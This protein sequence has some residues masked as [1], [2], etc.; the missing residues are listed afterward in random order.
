MGF[1]LPVAFALAILL[2][3]IVAMYLLKLRRTEQVVSSVYLWQR[4]VRDVEAN[5]PWQRL[6]R[7]LLLILQLL[8]LVALI[9]ALA[10]PFTWAQGPASEA[11]IL[12]LDTSASMAATD[13][14]PTR[15]G[16]AQAEARRLVDGLPP[17]ARVTVLAAGEGARLLVASSQDRQAIYRAI[18]G[19]TPG[20]ATSDLTAALELASAVAAR[21]PDTEIVV[22]SDGRVSLPQQLALSGRVRYVPV[23][24]SGDNQAI[25]AL[26]LEAESD[27]TLTAFAQVANYGDE[28]VQRRLALLA[29]GQLVSAYDLEIE[30]GG[31]RAVVFDGFPPGTQQVQASLAGE[32]ALPVDDRAWAVHRGAAPAAVTLLSE[33]NLFLETG[34]ALL[35]GLEVTT[36]RPRDWDRSEAP[37]A[38]PMPAPDGSPEPETPNTPRLTILDATVPLTRTLPPGNLLFI[39]PPRSTGYFTVTGTAAQPVPRPVG[40]DDSLLAHVDLSGAGV[41]EAVRLVL[42]D[43]ARLLVAGDLAG[44]EKIPLLF[45]GE[46]D[47]RRVA[48]LAFDL[49]RS[50]LP[51]QVAFPLLLANLAGWL[52]PGSGYEVPAQVDPGVAVS[53][54]LPPGAESL[55]VTRPDGSV[56][57][58]VPSDGRAAFA[59]TAQLG[60]YQA[61]WDGA[62]GGEVWFAVNLFSP[63]ES[64]VRPAE[65]LPL[66]AG[67]GDGAAASAQQAR[68]EWW[69]PLA[70]L[71]LGLLVAEWLVYHRGTLSGLRRLR[72]PSSGPS[73]SASFQAAF[74]PWL[75]PA[76]VT[77]AGAVVSQVS[78]LGLPTLSFV[79]PHVLWLLLLIPLAIVLGLLGRRRLGRLRHWFGLGLR[80]LLLAL[81]V[82]ALAGTQ[83]R[84]RTDV[85]TT[86]FLLDVSDSVPAAEQ[87]RG[88]AFVHQSLAAMPGGDRAAVVLFGRDALVERLASAERALPEFASVPVTTRTDIASALQLALALLP[89]E[90][91]K[92]LVL[93]SDGR[94]NLGE[95][96]AQAELAAAHAIELSFVPLGGP[97]GEV[98]VQLQSL[99]APA[100]VRQGQDF[101]LAVLVDSTARVGATLR[102]FGDGQLIHSQEVRLQ[103]GANRFLVPVQ[104]GA[105]ASGRSSG[106]RRFRAQVVPDADARLQ[107]N[108][109]GAFTVVHGPPQVL[110][111]EGM[112]GEADNL[113]AA[114]EAAGMDVLLSSPDQL[115]A[116][117]PDLASYEAVVLAN[118]PAS[119][120][121]GGA[122]EALQVFVRDLGRGLL[123]T[124]G[125][126]A[127][128]AGGYLRTAL[129]ETLPV[130]MDVRT[131]EQTPN[132][133]LVVA[134]DKSG[135][136]GRCHCDNPDLNQSYVRAEVGQPKVDIAKEAIMRAASALGPLDT[137]GVVA[138]DEV[139]A[140]AVEMGPVGGF[141]ALER[142]IG[143]IQAL[144]QTN[145]RAGV[146]TAYDALLDADA[147][148]KHVI[149]LT[150]GWVH[151]GDLGQ[152][153]TEM[154]EQGITLSVVAAGEGSAEYLAGLAE[155]GGGRYYPAEDILSVP[156]FFLKETVKAVGQYIIEEP[157]YPLPTAPSPVLR[158]LDPAL[159]P[160]LLGY[161]GTTPKGTARVV[162]GTPR[163]DPLL[164]T[165]QY[166]LG[167]AAVWTSDLKGRWA[168]EWLAWEGFPRFGA[169]LVA[170]T[171]PAPR[172]EGISAQAG[173]EDDLAVVRVEARDDQGRP[174]SFLD[175]SASLVGPDLEPQEFA[176]EQ[177]GAGRYEVGIDLAD[178]GTYLVRVGVQDGDEVLG[179][180][181]LGLVVPYSPEYRQSGPDGAFLRGLAGLTGGEQLTEP[182]AVFTHDLPA[183]SRGREVWA[184]LLLVAALLFPLDVALRRLNV[185]RREFGLAAAWIRA[186]LP[187]R[188]AG[189]PAAQRALGQLFQARD[190]VRARQ[191]RTPDAAESSPPE[192]RPVPQT[193]HHED[194]QDSQDDRTPSNQDEALARLRRAKDRARRDPPSR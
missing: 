59:D 15:L 103:P 189:E 149:L 70:W 121:A 60:L 146:E 157:F 99:D 104:A 4:L 183:V 123:V 40:G 139:A 173:L 135:S 116:S 162:L 9:L 119:A 177:V 150:D 167:R 138:F 140:W 132:L 175:V 31:Q 56:V 109:A 113:S 42:P 12:I 52:A 87:A 48:V 181:T 129:E 179:Q 28:P 77:A 182:A 187:A 101:D 141:A 68:R 83:L 131:R 78:Q 117:L 16:A 2:P 79:Y 188:R 85:L 58:V 17:E 158:E 73:R 102:V 107:N 27:G 6:R 41:L 184:A 112:A 147:R 176:L 191:E 108:E 47:G 65:Q 143:P 51:L 76:F 50:D 20:A 125:E 127:F 7:N 170:W 145:L 114:L 55:Q 81:V 118:V 142:A 23:G 160:L 34:L 90:G 174:R 192:P 89:D 115:P 88:E 111:V 120:L 193:P 66:L 92:R 153:A 151:T 29:D 61:T 38:T 33:G 93:L 13:V 45:A 133:A 100:D 57:R 24:S 94:Q 122:M 67:A 35:P 71:A 126:D 130:D 171:L 84:L 152:M 75:S 169:Q 95:A 72:R 86:V 5:A 30:A 10:R 22:L 43:W 168:T 148:I 154:Q 96:L 21:Q 69:R 82:L 91:A 64:D 14:S 178:T 124:G 19:A 18:D 105:T 26:S 185:G 39:A 63:S 32:D 172:V 155:Q 106:F 8:F 190:R 80:A 25:S 44:G 186:R 97:P 166:G 46:A 144:G 159:L 161:N 62:E 49:H 137:L 163:G 37:G 194:R 54:S 156:D 110:V 3:I 36:V 134:V 1:L 74:L 180:Q 164:A 98:E 11:L 136:M 165:W 53:F 128:G